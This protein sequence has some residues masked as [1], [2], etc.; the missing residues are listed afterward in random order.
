MYWLKHVAF[1]QVSSP[2]EPVLHMGSIVASLTLVPFSS[3]FQSVVSL[4]HSLPSEKYWRQLKQ[5]ESM[6]H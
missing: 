2:F 1:A 6:S 3:L 5:K 4:S